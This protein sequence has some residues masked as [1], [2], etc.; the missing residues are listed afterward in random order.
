[1]K[2]IRKLAKNKLEGISYIPLEEGASLTEI[3]A[4]IE[5]PGDISKRSANIVF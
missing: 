4:E 5:G 3:F 1:M 2:E